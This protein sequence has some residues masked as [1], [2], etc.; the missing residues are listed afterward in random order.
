MASQSRWQTCTRTSSRTSARCSGFGSAGNDNS[1]A[2]GTTLSTVYGDIQGIAGQKVADL[3]V[4]TLGTIGALPAHP[5]G[6]ES[7]DEDVT[8]DGGA[9]RADDPALAALLFSL[10]PADG[11][12]VGN[13]LSER[14]VE[15]ALL[16]LG[17]SVAMDDYESVQGDALGT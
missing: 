17:A 6:D 8:E 2:R 7:L 16:K 1:D 13:T 11:S 3:P 12:N 9:P 4:L 5:G 10:I 15:K 14:F